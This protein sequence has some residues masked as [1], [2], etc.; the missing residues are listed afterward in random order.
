VSFY[1]RL[2]SDEVPHA[3]VRARFKG[4][5]TE[6][7]A[8]GEGYF[9]LDL[10]PSRPLRGG[11]WHDVALSLVEPAGAAYANGRALVPDARARFGVISDVDDTVVMSGVA[12]RVAM[13]VRLA[14]SNARTRK[15]FAGVAA[16]YRALHAER[17]PVFYV[18]KSPW[19]L[20]EPLV[21]FFEAQGLPQG[22]LLL[23]D[24]G[25]R[26]LLGAGREHKRTAIERILGTYPR[27]PFVLIG[28]SGE[29][30]PEI[31]ADV[32]R[33]HPDRIRCVYIR[34]VRLETARVA[35]IERLTAELAPTG[36][37]LVLAPDSELAA[38]HAAAE[39]LIPAS[40]LRAV[41][42]DRKRD[43]RYAGAKERDR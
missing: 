23:R 4:R 43:A 31:Y 17:N 19:N 41:R 26:M 25:T 39:G 40:A 32:V 15:P 13:L 22:P 42:A 38:V 5:T 27:L 36:C 1:R 6:V 28:D 2:E 21:Q 29:R 10:R 7:V 8:D 30:D 35:A 24:Y 33:R 3:R 34:S 14:L 12:R 16:F 9:Q 20:Y 37:Q 11:A 18:S